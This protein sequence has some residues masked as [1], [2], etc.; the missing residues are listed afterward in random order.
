M[1]SYFQGRAG[2]VL[3]SDLCWTGTAR[4]IIRRHDEMRCLDILDVCMIGNSTEPWF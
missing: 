1:I 4:W 2:A 3:A